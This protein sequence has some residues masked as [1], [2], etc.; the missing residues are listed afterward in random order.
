VKGK[1]IVVSP[2]RSEINTIT[3][4]RNPGSL[5]S[6]MLVHG[7]R[8]SKSLNRYS[9]VRSA[10]FH[11]TVLG[12]EHLHHLCPRTSSSYSRWSVPQ[13]VSVSHAAVETLTAD[14]CK[15]PW[16]VFTPITHGIQDGTSGRVQ[17]AR[18]H[19]VPVKRNERSPT[20]ALVET[21]VILWWW[22]GGA[23]QQSTQRKGVT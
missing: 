5:Q 18:H 2:R 13:L 1:S 15:V 23:A 4:S 17:C 6:N 14:R 9:N 19:R 10:N 21:V 11:L 8:S 16:L 20:L 3:I 12:K 22:W 7:H